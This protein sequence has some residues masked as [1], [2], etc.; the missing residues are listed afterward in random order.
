MNTGQACEDCLYGVASGN[1]IECHFSSRQW[2]SGEY[3]GWWAF[4]EME[5]YDWCSKFVDQ[6]EDNQDRF[7][8]QK[9]M[10]T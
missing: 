8:L 9:P 5:K 7:D 6:N 2:C 10:R 1:M 4:P 3:D